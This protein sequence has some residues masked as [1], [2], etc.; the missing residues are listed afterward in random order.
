MST[1]LRIAGITEESIVD[2]PGIR[3]V[4]FA[5]GCRHNCPGCHNPQTH[6]M[7]GGTLISVDE[8]L[9]RMHQNPLL[10]GI[11]LSGG[12]PF[13][14]S[15]GFR[16]LASRAREAGYH[17]VT[18]TGYTYEQLRE[19]ADYQ[20]D[21]AGLLKN[22]DL[23]I[24]GPFIKDLHDPLLVFR[25]SENQRMVDVESSLLTGAIRLVAV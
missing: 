20:P 21:W 11:T 5:Q 15:K 10:D 17:V 9:E 12:D 16:E 18:Y 19:K 2:G 24:D 23:L 25:G 7:D 22:T 1:Q 6:A 8:I 4:V 14:Q 13:E 3:F